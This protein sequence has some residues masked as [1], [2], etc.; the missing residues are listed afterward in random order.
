MPDPTPPRTSA[1]KVPGEG[2]SVLIS[3]CSVAALFVLSVTR[4]L[5]AFNNKP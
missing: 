4:A 3:V 1:F 2:S 5:R